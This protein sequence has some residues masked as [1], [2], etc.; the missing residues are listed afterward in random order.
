M[1][2]V[3]GRAIPTGLTADP[4]TWHARPIGLN[5][6]SSP[7]CKQVH[8]WA[9]ATPISRA[10]LQGTKLGR[11]TIAADRKPPQV[12]LSFVP[13]DEPVEHALEDRGTGSHQISGRRAFTLSG[14]IPLAR[15][16]SS[17]DRCASVTRPTRNSAPKSSERI[18]SHHDSTIVIPGKA[19]PIKPGSGVERGKFRE[20]TAT[21]PRSGGIITLLCKRKASSATCGRYGPM[22]SAGSPLKRLNPSGGAFS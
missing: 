3:P 2:R 18:A 19:P 11:P 21:A 5:R 17:H 9:R 16:F 20:G 8:A 4:E 6:V 7:E 12:R 1:Y 10:R 15:R 14:K 22:I 13:R